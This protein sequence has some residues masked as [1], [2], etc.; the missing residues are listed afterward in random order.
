MTLR[1]LLEFR[2]RRRT[3][4]STS[5]KTRRFAVRMPNAEPTGQRGTHWEWLGTLWNSGGKKVATKDKRWYKDVGLGF[6]TPSEAING[7]YIGTPVQSVEDAS[8][9]C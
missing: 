5:S 9:Q 1:F 2:S 7:T 6:K 8:P 4:S 3:R